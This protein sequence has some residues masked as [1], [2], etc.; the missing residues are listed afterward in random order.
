MSRMTA[1][2]YR[3]RD[4]VSG[5]GMKKPRRVYEP[6]SRSV[7]TGYLELTALTLAVLLA[8]VLAERYL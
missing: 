8:L 4:K 7:M 3:R 2:L 1:R 6:W 5:G